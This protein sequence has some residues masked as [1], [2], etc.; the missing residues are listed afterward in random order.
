MRTFGLTMPYGVPSREY[1]NMCRFSNSIEDGLGVK[2]LS[3]K[4]LDHGRKGLTLEM[5]SKNCSYELQWNGG[6][7]ILGRFYN[8]RRERLFEGS[9]SVPAEWTRLLSVVQGCE[10]RMKLET[11]RLPRPG[12]RI[13]VAELNRSSTV[14]GILF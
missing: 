5:A 13:D 9:P 1:A 2:M 11:S 14:S 12:I 7:M 6:S 4:A 10:E 3:L 8:G